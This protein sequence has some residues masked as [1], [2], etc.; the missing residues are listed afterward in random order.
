M[1]FL[2]WAYTPFSHWDGFPLLFPPR[3]IA[4]LERTFRLLHPAL[5]RASRVNGNARN[6]GV[7]YAWERAVF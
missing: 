3:H 6:A 5:L 4:P 1:Q 7:G 2:H